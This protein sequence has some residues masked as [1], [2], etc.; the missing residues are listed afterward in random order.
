MTCGRGLSCPGLGLSGGLLG[1]HELDE[2]GT[3]TARSP[4]VVRLVASRA[5]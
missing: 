5:T 1:V 4:S 3:T 2:S